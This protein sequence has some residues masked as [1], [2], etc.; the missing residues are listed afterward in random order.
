MPFNSNIATNPCNK[1][2]DLLE[3]IHRYNYQNEMAILS[4][5]MGLVSCGPAQLM[6]A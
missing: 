6:R 1:S 5:R 2:L 4:A 3:Y